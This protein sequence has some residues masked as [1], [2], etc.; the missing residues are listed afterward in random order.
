MRCS[1]IS[2]QLAAAAQEASELEILKKAVRS[3]FFHKEQDTS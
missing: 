1:Y 2:E 3:E